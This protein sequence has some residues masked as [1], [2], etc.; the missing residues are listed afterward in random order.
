MQK[1]YQK[2]FDENPD[3]KSEEIYLCWNTGL[4]DTTKP[5]R[6]HL[7]GKQNGIYKQT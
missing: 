7:A 5:T 3:V 4:W 2:V 1:Q 6:Q